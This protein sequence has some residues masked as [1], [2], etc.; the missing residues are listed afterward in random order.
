MTG[1]DVRGLVYAVLELADRVEHGDDPLE[2]MRVDTPAVERPANPVR[3]VARLFTSEVHDKPWFHD[4]GFWRRYLSM[5]VAQR[6]NRVNLMVGLGYN[7]PWRIMDPYLYFAYP[8]LVDVPG[9]GV[10]VPQLSDE[11]RDR[12]LAMLRFIS[13]E[14][15]ARGLE[16]RF[17]MWTHAFRWFES[18]DAPYTIEGLDADRHAAY[19]GEAIGI[20]LDACPSI[21]GLTLRTH[22][23]SGVPERSWD[24]WK[25]VFDGIVRVGPP[26]RARPA[27]EGAR[28][29]DPRPRGRDRPARSQS[30]RSSRPSTWGCRTTRRRCASSIACR[31][32]AIRRPRAR[33]DS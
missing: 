17:G 24:F 29:G 15:V 5:V 18:E 19:C 31:P 10:R 23:E 6:F 30:R 14:A 21:G 11:E 32:I 7:F 8:F 1:S 3:S 26:D 9:S 27:R 2:A 16:F 12:N 22:G 28:P 33:R 25:K 4:E 20:L 13:D